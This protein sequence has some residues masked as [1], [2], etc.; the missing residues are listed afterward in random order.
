MSIFNLGCTH[1]WGPWKYLDL[2]DYGTAIIMIRKCHCGQQET[3]KMAAGWGA[4]TGL[5]D[6]HFRRIEA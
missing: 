1:A 5:Y 6:E 2:D 4:E 3:R